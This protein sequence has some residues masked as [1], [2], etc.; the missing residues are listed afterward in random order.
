MSSVY[1]LEELTWWLRQNYE[2]VMA[3]MVSMQ[4]VPMYRAELDGKCSHS[5]VKKSGPGKVTEVMM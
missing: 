4:V 3:Y 5:G 2:L 1:L